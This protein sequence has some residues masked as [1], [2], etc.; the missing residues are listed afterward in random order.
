MTLAPAFIVLT[1]VALGLALVASWASLRAT[2]RDDEPDPREPTPS[3]ERAALMEEKQGLLRALK[4]LEHE[5]AVGKI[6]AEDHARLE[7]AYRARAKEIMALL[8]RDLEP[9]LARA[10]SLV[11]SVSRA[12]GPGAPSESGR[13]ATEREGRDR[14]SSRQDLDLVPSSGESTSISR[15]GEDAAPPSASDGD[16]LRERARALREEAERLERLAAV[17]DKVTSDNVT[18]DKVISNEEDPP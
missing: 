13:E 14:A 4:D 7:R 17:S 3:A 1:S 10:E 5:Y 11:A 18:S 15:S 8:E 2:L 12:E 16:A 6:D 9:Y